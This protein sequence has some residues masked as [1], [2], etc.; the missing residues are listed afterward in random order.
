MGYNIEISFNV[1]KHSSVTNA[2][3]H[4]KEM[5][6]RHCCDYCYEDYDFDSKTQ[7]QRNHCIMNVSFS[8]PNTYFLMGF[9]R[10]IQRSEG[11]YIELI[12]DDE[13]RSILYASQ[14]YITQKMDKGVAK[15]FN[16]NKRERSYSDDDNMILNTVKKSK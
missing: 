2:V 3:E 16:K 13:S 12:Y 14:Y 9:L 6:E 1:L 8:H 7:F 10:N 5:A 4:V 15:I 11:L